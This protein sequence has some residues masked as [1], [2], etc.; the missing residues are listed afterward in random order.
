MTTDNGPAYTGKRF[1]RLPRRLRI[2]HLRTR[3]YTPCT[4]GKAECFIQTLLRGWAY[5]Y[6]YATSRQ[7]NA[8]C[9][10]GRDTTTSSAAFGHRERLPASR[11]GLLVNN[12]SRNYN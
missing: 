3:P 8:E 9:L 11:L 5:R 6:C 4:N 7:R 12:V 1:G 2:R 10:I